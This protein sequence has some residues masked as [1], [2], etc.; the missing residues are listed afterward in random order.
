LITLLDKEEIDVVVVGQGW[1]GF[2]LSQ[3]AQAAGSRGVS[4]VFAL[5][6]LSS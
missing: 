1:T 5:T 2:T 3:A 4:V 6:S